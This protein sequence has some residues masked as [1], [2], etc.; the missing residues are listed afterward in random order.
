VTG[1]QY[2]MLGIGALATLC[3]VLILIMRIRTVVSGRIV[4][5]VVVGEKIGSH[6]HS[7]NDHKVTPM[8]HAVFEFQHEGKTFRCESSLGKAG[9]TSEGARVRVRYLPSDPQNTA[10]IDALGAMWGF[11]IMALVVGAVFIAVGLYD[12]GYFKQ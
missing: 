11:P 3:G 12:A 4:D 9:R 10:E 5:G 7:S 6:V 8:S 1:F 2:L